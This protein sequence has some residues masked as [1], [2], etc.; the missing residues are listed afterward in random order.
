M[1]ELG[2]A[3]SEEEASLLV[4]GMEDDTVSEDEEFVDLNSQLA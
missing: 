2:R 4:T 3:A 1:E